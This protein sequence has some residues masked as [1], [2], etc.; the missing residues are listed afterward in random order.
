VRLRR[1]EL[2]HGLLDEQRFLGALRA[3]AV[4]LGHGDTLDLRRA[5]LAPIEIE[6]GSGSPAPRTA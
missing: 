5:W 6:L 2:A 1:W 4:H 3:V